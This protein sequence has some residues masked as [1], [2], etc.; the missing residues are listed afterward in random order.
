MRP[1]PTTDVITGAVYGSNQ[2]LCGNVFSTPRDRNCAKTNKGQCQKSA[3]SVRQKRSNRKVSAA[4]AN[5]LRAADGQVALLALEG[6]IQFGTS[7]NDPNRH[8]LVQRI[9]VHGRLTTPKSK[10][11]RRVDMSRELRG[12][13]LELRDKRM[14]Q[15]FMKG[16]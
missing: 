11:S 10:K 16:K 14:Q 5:D 15:A 4:L 12:V 3:L 9:Y 8:I 2:I 6:D 7:D 13:L 1:N